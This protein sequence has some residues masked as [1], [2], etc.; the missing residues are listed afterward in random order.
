MKEYS[1]PE[2][3]VL[4]KYRII[5]PAGH[6]T[7]DGRTLANDEYRQFDLKSATTG[8]KGG[9]GPLMAPDVVDKLLAADQTPDKKWLDWIFYQAAGGE[10]GE[11]M[12]EAALQQIKDRFIDERVNGFQHPE[13]HE[14]IPP[15][16]REEATARWA[17]SEPK[18]RD[19]LTVCDQDAVQKLN[20]F[21][22]FR[23]WKGNDNIYEKVVNAVTR[24]QKFYKKLLQ[25]NKEIA[26]EDKEPV[27]TEPSDIKTYEDMEKIS[28][29]VERYFASK[30]AREDIRYS[31][32]PTRQDDLIYDD[33]YVTVMAPL[34][35]AAAVQYGYPSWAWANRE[36]FDEV[37]SNEGQDYRNVW[38]ANTGRGSIYVY[39]HFKVPVPGWVARTG[40]QFVLHHLD[41]LALELKANDLRG[42]KNWDKWTVWDQENRNT[43]SIKDVKDMIMAEPTRADSQDEEIPITRGGNM[44]ST[45][46]EAA[47]IVKHLDAAIKAVVEWAHQFDP[48]LIKQDVTKLD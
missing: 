37:L 18:F 26:R 9:P 25:M 14:Y 24:F 15:V 2:L 23:H 47:N 31:G 1:A 7:T 12:R 46:E 45:P 6:K 10:K 19:I 8:Q 4:R 11:Q 36:T 13:T 29:K 16:S 41:D 32:H 17:K 33:D 30:A 3:A 40:G 39:I 20:T 35:W 21:G 34:T 48:N 38:K 22:Y 43:M 5:W 28:S 27:A 44:I 42:L